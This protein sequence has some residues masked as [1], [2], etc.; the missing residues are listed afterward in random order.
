[1]KGKLLKSELGW[2]VVTTEQSGKTYSWVS[3][4]LLHP[5][6]I[7]KIR[8][9]DGTITDHVIGV[10]HDSYPDVEF[11][12]IDTWE[13]GNVGVNGLTYA[14][15]KK[16]ERVYTETEIKSLLEMA[17]QKI[18]RRKGFTYSPSAFELQREINEMLNQN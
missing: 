7:K 6:D 10:S 8:H 18:I 3:T 4:F 13:N 11:E 12:L 17:Y 1:M 5:D 2:A 16:R 9:D 14:K 15:L